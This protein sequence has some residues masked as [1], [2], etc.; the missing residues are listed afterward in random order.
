MKDRFFRFSTRVTKKQ[1]IVSAVVDTGCQSY[2]AGFKIVKKL[3]LSTKNL[4]T[5]NLKMHAA[6][7]HDVHIL[8][9][10]IMR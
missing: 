8:G 7:N 5:V 6:D 9:T 10:A 2:L 1:S 3:G 4:I